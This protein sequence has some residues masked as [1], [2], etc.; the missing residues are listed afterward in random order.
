M[1]APVDCYSASVCRNNHHHQE[2][3]GTRHVLE[4]LLVFLQQLLVQFLSGH[5][6][7]RLGLFLFR[8]EDAP[9]K[10]DDPAHVALADCS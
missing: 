4:V 5:R 10:C 8:K 6:S 7:L 3:D 1:M 9:E 2:D